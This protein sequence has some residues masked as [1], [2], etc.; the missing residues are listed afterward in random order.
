MTYKLTLPTGATHEVPRVTEVIRAGMPKPALHLWELR[1][2]SDYS[3]RHPDLDADLAIA[4]WRK[5]VRHA[6]KRGTAVHKWIAAI[7]NG[8]RPPAL[9]AS[10]SGYKKAFTDW[11][12]D[13]L[14]PA[15]GGRW[16]PRGQDHVEQTL[17][18]TQVTVAGTA[19]F[20]CNGRLYDWKT[21]EKRSDKGVWPDHIAQ[22]GAYTSM[23][24][25]VNDG[26]IGLPAIVP[27]VHTASIVRL[28]ADGTY[29]TTTFAGDDLR[30]A[31]NLWHAV[32]TVA[33]AVTKDR[34][35]TTA[36]TK[37]KNR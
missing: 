8:D 28:Y 12:V 4:G 23:T 1:G 31:I 21:S 32:R 19:D 34:D 24:R 16:S 27:L 18:D 11:M 37:E 17:T 2:V 29:D 3:V 25:L 30:D 35:T 22:L 26:Q 15:T 9:L 33:R 20:I 7:L 6:A 10:Q 36:D 14:C 13:N 5:S